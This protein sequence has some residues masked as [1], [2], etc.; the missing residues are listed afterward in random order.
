MRTCWARVAP[1]NPI[2]CYAL[3]VQAPLF[4]H[5]AELRIERIRDRS[6]SYT[7]WKVIE[8]IDEDPIVVHEKADQIWL[9]TSYNETRPGSWVIVDEA[10]R[11]KRTA[12]MSSTKNLY[13]PKRNCAPN[14]SRADYGMGTK[15]TLIELAKFDAPGDPSG[16][17]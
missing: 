13:L 10:L 2:R 14:V 3:R 4:G 7:E 1:D 9:D 5:N 17:T 16:S 6:V 8:K 11:I 15:S 12:P